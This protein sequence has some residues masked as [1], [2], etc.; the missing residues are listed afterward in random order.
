[1]SKGKQ[2]RDQAA[3]SGAGMAW[4]AT[5]TS[6]ILLVLL[7]AF[8]VQNQED[9]TITLFGLKATIASGLA[10]L[11]AAAGGGLLVAAAGTARILQLKS[12]RHQRKAG[13]F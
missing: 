12:R 5:I 6:L 3:A 2:M 10:L 4:S 1:M 13:L 8:I 11:I 9:L 7:I